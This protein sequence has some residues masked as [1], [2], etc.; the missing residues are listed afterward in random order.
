MSNGD[1][2]KRKKQKEES[3]RKKALLKQYKSEASLCKWDPKKNKKVCKSNKG[4]L[5]KM[6]IE[7]PAEKLG[8]VGFGVGLLA[9][10]TGAGGFKKKSKK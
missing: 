2:E 8:A 1:K 6:G 9:A 3:K 4:V 5:A 7:T 10:F